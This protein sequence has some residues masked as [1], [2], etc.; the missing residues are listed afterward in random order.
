MTF[1]A[2]TTAAALKRETP[3]RP[4]LAMVLG[5]GFQHALARLEVAREIGY[6]QVP[7]FPTVGVTGHAGKLVIGHFDKVPVI[8][9]KGRAHYYEGHEMERLTFPIRVLAEM[10]VRTVLL[11]NA[12]GAVNRKFRAGDFMALTDHINLMGV[13]P[14][15]GLV[16]PGLPQFVDL[17]RVYDRRLIEL[18]KRSARVAKMRLHKGVYMAVCGPSYETPAEIRA[19]AQLGADAIGMSTVPEAIVA[20]QCGLS[21]AALSCIT[22]KAGGDEKTG[23][24]VHQ[25]VLTMGQSKRHEMAT[26]LKMFAFLHAELGK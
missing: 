13:N 6:A 19:F 11:T 21:V 9:L 5:S 14:L 18:L 25:D 23:I 10:G 3:I 2:K 8:V 1:D 16:S 22:N 24:L 12:A 15:R 17:T 7:G 26:F 20:R 4:A